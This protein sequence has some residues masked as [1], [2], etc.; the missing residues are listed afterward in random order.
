MVLAQ[1]LCEEEASL[2]ELSVANCLEKLSHI[3]GAKG[4]RDNTAEERIASILTIGH[5]F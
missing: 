5:L 4:G 1:D 3:V 2:S